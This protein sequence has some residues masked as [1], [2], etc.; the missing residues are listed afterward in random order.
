VVVLGSAWPSLM[1]VIASSH[2]YITAHRK[3]SECHQLI[4][5]TEENSISD[6][7]QPIPIVSV[8]PP[9]ASAVVRNV[10]I[11]SR[12]ARKLLIVSDA[13]SAKSDR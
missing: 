6:K 7:V 9:A 3:H 13:R 12:P 2:K 5:E 1:L 8:R 11:S 10:E 4:L